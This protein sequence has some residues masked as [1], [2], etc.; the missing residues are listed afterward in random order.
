MK[1]PVS[2]SSLIKVIPVAAIFV[3]AAFLRLYRLPEVP[4]GLH[5]DEAMNGINGLEAWRTGHFQVFYPENG[6]REGLFINVQSLVLGLVGHNEPWVLRLVSA[7]FGTLTVI[8]FYFFCREV[9]DESTARLAALLMATSVWHI[10]ISRFGTRPVSAL[11]FL[12]YG[13]YLFWRSTRSLAEGSRGY[14]LEAI[15]AGLVYGLGFHTYTAYRITPLM[16]AALLPRMARQYGQRNVAKV[17]IIAASV[18]MLAVLPLALYFLGHR[19][20]FVGRISEVSLAASSHPIHQLFSNIAKTVGM[21]AFV[22]DENWRHNLSGQPMLFWPVAILCFI[23]VGL[24]VFRQRWLFAFW[25]AGM[26]PAVLSTED[27]PHALRSSLTIPAALF[28]AA[29]GGIWLWRRI[30]PMLPPVGLRVL[31]YAIAMVL[32]VQA[33]H[34][35][36]IKWGRNLTVAAWFYDNTLIHAR[37]LLAAPHDIPKYVVFSAEQGRYDRGLPSSARSIM[38]LTD[39]FSTERQEK[40]G[41]HYLLSDQTNQIARGWVYVDFIPP[42]TAY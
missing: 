41:V 26:L 28:A 40:M 6:G 42:P 24:A 8:A 33:Y 29:L 10:T 4:P 37:S 22:G 38:F 5:P 15:A 3:L 36:F 17:G 11:F 20:D 16:V 7:V 9:S 35:Y 32:A 31:P 23:G 18:A 21:Y 2:R 19:A 30:A 34:T 13:L 12:L 1:T 39:T 14:V 25:V 27:L